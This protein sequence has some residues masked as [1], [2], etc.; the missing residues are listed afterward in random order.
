MTDNQGS[1]RERAHAAL[2][3]GRY[4]EVLDAARDWL[5]RKPNAAEAYHVAGLALARM[6]DATEAAKSFE[7]AEALGGGPSCAFNAGNAWQA[8]GDRALALAAWRRAAVGHEGLGAHAV[9]LGRALVAAG[10]REI[11]PRVLASAARRDPA[12]QDAAMQALVALAAADR[13]AARAPLP[14]GAAGPL[15]PPAS[16][17]IV[18]CSIDDAKFAAFSSTIAARF[19]G[20]AHEVIRIPDAASL[21]EGYARGL[22]R[23][24]G[25]AVV[26]SHDDVDLLA[27]DAATRLASHLTHADLVGAAGATRV[28]GPAVFWAGH[29]ALHGWVTY[30]E[31]GQADYE[32]TAMSLG[33]PRVDGI[34]AL[35]GVLIAC[36]RDAAEAV[37][38]DTATFD[39][40]HLYDLDF[41]YRAHLAGRKLAV[42]CDLG[43]VHASKG[44]FDGGWQRYADRF[45]AKFP[46]LAAPQ[47][48]THYYS[49]RVPGPDDVLA[50][51]RRLAELAA[52]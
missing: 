24:T 45:R 30:R 8:S 17:S 15:A 22:A 10:D 51:Q 39:G 37:G 23:S 52:A 25:D 36:R 31:P 49:A 44:A 5:G 19:A 1:A 2:R 40:F 42:A 46:A 18:V 26:F 12:S 14:L 48:S 28:T 3:E 43:V 7:N 11:G 38:F 9:A 50:F 4:A 34:A 35:D 13:H 41:S 29:P 33:G 16:W 32:V 20:V 27:P 47:G 21:S 6:G